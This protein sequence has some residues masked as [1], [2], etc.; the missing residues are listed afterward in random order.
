M[1]HVRVP[2]IVVGSLFVAAQFVR[3]ARTNPRVDGDFVAPVEVK[4][5]LRRACY[6]CH[7][8][9][10]GWPW[11]SE[12]APFS[13]LTHREVSEGRRRLNFSEWAEY[14]SDP[15]TAARKLEQIS[16]SLAHDDMP[17][18]Y[19]QLLHPGVRLTDAERATLLRWVKQARADL[20]PPT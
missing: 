9:E 16:E 5:T 15:E 20:P 13:W 14:V 6:D 10:T 1:R 2:L 7:S 19:Y 3:F 12:V 11:Y 8:N 4:N 18:W 17:P